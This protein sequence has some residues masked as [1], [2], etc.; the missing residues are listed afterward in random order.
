MVN[1]QLNTACF[2]VSF[3]PYFRPMLEG[4][5]KLDAGT[6]NRA[7]SNQFQIKTRNRSGKDHD[8]CNGEYLGSGHKASVE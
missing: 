5:G 2:S 4:A 8:L 3:L 1:K 7:Y 6:A